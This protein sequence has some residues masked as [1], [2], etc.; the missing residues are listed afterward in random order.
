MNEADPLHTKLYV[1]KIRFEPSFAELDALA[2]ALFNAHEHA[3]VSG[4]HVRDYEVTLASSY[5]A[6]EA[7]ERKRWH[8]MAR[9]AMAMGATGRPEFIEF[10]AVRDADVVYAM[11]RPWRHHHVVQNMA[12]SGFP[13]QPSH[14]QGFMTNLERFVTREQAVTIADKAR[15]LDI[16]RPKTEPKSKLFSEDIW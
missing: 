8:A 16:V 11:P 9:V 5:G 7:N 12:E 15:Q 4:S 2:R 6:G 1:L 13:Q 10:V 3:G 14:V